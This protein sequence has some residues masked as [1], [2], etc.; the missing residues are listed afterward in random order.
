M[1]VFY[2]CLITLPA[3]ARD[4]S[5]FKIFRLNLGPP[6]H[7]TEQIVQS[8]SSVVER[9]EHKADH[10]QLLSTKVKNSWSF[11]C[12]L[13][14]SLHACPG[15]T[16]VW[17]HGG[18]FLGNWNSRAVLDNYS[19]YC[20]IHHL[21][22]LKRRIWIYSYLNLVISRWWGLSWMWWNSWTSGGNWWRCRSVWYVIPDDI[23]CAFQRI[24][25]YVW[26]CSDSTNLLQLTAVVGLK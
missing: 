21:F 11:T 7:P 18:S 23:C 20:Y 1:C 6:F 12:T 26:I 4:F 16:Y 2:V 8:C 19:F 3:H 9:P 25:V 5:L 13:C 10:S 22:P 24:I 17:K 14:V 15:T